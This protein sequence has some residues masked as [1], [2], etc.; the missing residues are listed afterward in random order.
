MKPSILISNTA[1]KS[2][3]RFNHKKLAN[4]STK[5]SLLIPV[6]A[7]TLKAWL[8]ST[9][10]SSTI[11][12]TK[13]KN[14]SLTNKDIPLLI[15]TLQPSKTSALKKKSL[16]LLNPSSLELL[17]LLL[18][19]SATPKKSLSSL[20]SPTLSLVLD[21]STKKSKK[22]TSWKISLSKHFPIRRCIIDWN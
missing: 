2:V 15:L 1:N 12:F 16:L 11:S 17:S 13:T 20:N 6:T 8:I 10:K 4:L 22:V 19:H 3:S 14:S 21:S 7:R 9:R 5:S 18:S